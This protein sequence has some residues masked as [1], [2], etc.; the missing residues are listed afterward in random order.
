MAHAPMPPPV[1]E[2]PAKR[3]ALDGLSITTGLAWRKLCWALDP[4]KVDPP[5]ACADS[6]TV[7]VVL[8]LMIEIVLEVITSFWPSSSRPSSSEPSSQLSS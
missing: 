1:N 4:R 5:S 7:S 8:S 6:R 3:R 2:K